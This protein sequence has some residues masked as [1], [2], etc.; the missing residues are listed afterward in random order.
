[1]VRWS[2]L[3]VRDGKSRVSPCEGDVKLIRGEYLIDVFENSA[4]PVLDWN[5][6][7]LSSATV[8]V[9]ELY[10]TCQGKDSACELWN[11]LLQVLEV[12]SSHALA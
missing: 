11:N 4:T 3:V 2:Q 7:V 9:S 5:L 6:R 12:V 10:T 8:I 1:M